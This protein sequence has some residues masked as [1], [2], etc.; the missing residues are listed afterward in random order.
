MNNMLLQ[1]IGATSNN[2]SFFR[3][4]TGRG[5]TI[6]ATLSYLR[7]TKFLGTMA[8]FLFPYYIIMEIEGG[9]D[10]LQHLLKVSGDVNLPKNAFQHVTSAHYIEINRRYFN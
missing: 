10:S 3:W 4:A 8:L 5:Y 1:G 6:N 7:I 9:D 2:M